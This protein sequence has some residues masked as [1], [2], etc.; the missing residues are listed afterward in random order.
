MGSF[1]SGFLRNKERKKSKIPIKLIDPRAGKVVE[2]EVTEK[3]NQVA[4]MYLRMLKTYAEAL[5]QYG[6]QWTVTG[7]TVRITFD[8]EE[9]AE[10]A[11]NTWKN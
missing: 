9:M 3:D 1:F 5:K 2:L 4:E 8:N 10:V 6:S 7:K 11:R